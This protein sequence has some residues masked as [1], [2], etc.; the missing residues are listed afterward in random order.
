M[1][2]SGRCIDLAISEE[3]ARQTKL[4]RLRRIM[5]KTEYKGWDR[6]LKDYSLFGAWSEAKDT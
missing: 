3:W 2:R 5:I 4:S 1:Y 6:V